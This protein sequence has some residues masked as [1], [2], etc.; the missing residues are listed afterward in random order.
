ME[1]PLGVVVGQAQA[2]GQRATGMACSKI[3]QGVALGQ[4][5][6]ECS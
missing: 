1:L 5:S 2:F 6:T 4:T 3:G